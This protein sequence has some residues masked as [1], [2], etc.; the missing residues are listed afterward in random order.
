MITRRK[1]LTGIACLAAS[2]SSASALAQSGAFPNRPI[3]IIVPYAPGG[4]PDTMA[5]TIAQHMTQ[6]LGQPVIIDNRSGAGGL[7][8]CEALAK[9]PADGHTLLIVDAAHVAVN[10]VVYK[11]LPYDPQ[12]QFA[13]VSL[14]GTAPMFL[15]AHPSVEAKNFKEFITAVKANP[16]K[17]SYGSTGAGSLSHLGMETIKTA[18]NVDLLHVPYRGTGQAAPAIVGG[19][20]STLFAGLPSVGG[21]L[22]SGQLKVFAVNSPARSPQAPDV[23]TVAE[24][25]VPG[26][27]FAA[28]FGLVAPAGT[29]RDVIQKLAGAVADAT[30]RP[31]TRE[32]FAPLGIDPVG[33]S[34][35][36]FGTVMEKMVRKFGDA[37]RAAGL[38]GSQ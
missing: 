28:D 20:I 1:L 9:A 7:S 29:P 2:L 33:S 8:A 16:K 18:L 21:F 5:R 24:L 3:K 37:A 17:Y 32:R 13:P 6:S 12:K 35:E 15:V 27:D 36:D 30:R 23:P 22:R 14:V 26:F 10:P 25:G 4:L 38:A 19:E 31:E 11:K 34:P